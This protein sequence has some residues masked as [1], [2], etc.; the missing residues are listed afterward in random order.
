MIVLR[1]VFVRLAAVSLVLIATV[2][3]SIHLEFISRMIFFDIAI[4]IF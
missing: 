3:Y 1:S 4:L 2:Y